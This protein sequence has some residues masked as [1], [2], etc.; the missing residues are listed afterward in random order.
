MPA[1]IG[2]DTHIISTHNNDTHIISTHRDCSSYCRLCRTP[3][4][5]WSGMKGT[6]DHAR[7]RNKKIHVRTS[8]WI[9]FIAYHRFQGWG[10]GHGECRANKDVILLCLNML[11]SALR[12]SNTNVGT[13]WYC[14]SQPLRSSLVSSPS[15]R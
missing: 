5:C 4:W 13:T 3:F 15:L 2:I 6:T 12:N 14:S 1:R 11:S 10:G 7:I 8:A 9:T